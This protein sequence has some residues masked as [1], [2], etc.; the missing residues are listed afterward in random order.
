MIR[1]GRRAQH[2]CLGI[3]ILLGCSRAKAPAPVRPNVTATDSSSNFSN[4]STVAPES[5]VAIK[6]PELRELQPGVRV[7]ELPRRASVDEKLFTSLPVEQTGLDFGHNW[8]PPE[9]YRLEVYNSLPGGGV[10]VGDIDADGWPDVF[11]TQPNVGS[12]LYRNL[13]GLRFEDVSSRVQA[14]SKAMGASFVDVDHDNDLDLYI[15]NNGLPNQLYLND[16]QGN[17]VEAAKQS[18]LNYQ[19]ASVMAAF[20]DYDR[21][22]DLDAYLVTNRMEPKTPPSPQRDANG[23]MRVADEDLEYIDIIEAQD[24]TRVIT[25]GQYDHLYRNNGDGTFTDVSQE[26]N[27]AGNHWGLSA[28]WWDYDRDGW[29]DLYVANDYYGPDHLYRNRGDGTFEDVAR[30]AFPHT[31]WYSMGT[32]A[33]DINNDG[34]L[35]FMGSDMSGTNHYKQKASMGDMGT[36]GWFLVHPMPRQYMRNALYLNTGTERFM[37]IAQLAGVAN[38][39][40]TWSLKFGDLDEDGWSDLYVTNGM[41]RDWTNSDIR[42]RS[43]RAATEAEKV[44]IWLE[45]P[46]RRDKNLAYCNLGNLRFDDRGDD[47]GLGESFV[48]YGAA[49]ADLGSRRRSGH[50]RQQRRN[51]SQ[52]LP[53]QQCGHAPNFV[54]V[55]RHRVTSNGVGFD[56]SSYY[57]RW[58]QTDA[59][60]E[61]LSRIYVVQRACGALWPGNQRKDYVAGDRVADRKNADVHRLTGRPI[62]CHRRTIDRIIT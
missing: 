32:D 10:C 44:Q 11:L 13:G 41:N 62:L 45:S 36:T 55:T 42:N 4:S 59:V 61:F 3:V 25:S 8:T 6:A 9:G 28:T 53:E 18:G 46:Q 1:T 12:R 60:P 23:N 35:D 39:D 31:P 24:Q 47:W 14:T 49:L 16:G 33:A 22:G 58:S 34:W 20:A 19:G 5:R 48:S 27:I 29:A 21:D 7:V 52:R 56:D 15:C 54:E 43:N 50:D 30:R 17:F 37:E 2:I 38:T 26:A 51:D 57:R 40:W